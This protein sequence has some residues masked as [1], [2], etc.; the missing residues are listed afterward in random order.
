MRR[1][2]GRISMIASAVRS[3]AGIRLSHHSMSC[4]SFS[5]CRSNA[6]NCFRSA[7]ACLVNTPCLNAF[8]L[9][10]GA[11]EPGAHPCIRQR[12]LPDTAGDRQGP[13][14]PCV[15]ARTYQHQ[16]GVAG[17]MAAHNL[18]LGFAGMTDVLFQNLTPIPMVVLRSHKERL[19]SRYSMSC[20]SFRDCCSNARSSL[21]ASTA[22]FVN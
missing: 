18:D 22:S 17:M 10:V 15:A 14:G 9:F 21:C 6:W 3:R 8:L 5:D 13:T 11:P 2:L 20:T 12:L 7:I 16:P 1:E 19:S 4:S